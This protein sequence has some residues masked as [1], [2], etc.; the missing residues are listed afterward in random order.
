[1]KKHHHRSTWLIMQD[2][3]HYYK[4]NVLNGTVNYRGFQKDSKELKVYL[5]D[6]Q[7]FTH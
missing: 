1:M 6:Y 2:G 7:V 4:K 3:I 5:N